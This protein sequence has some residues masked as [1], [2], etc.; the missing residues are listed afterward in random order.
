MTAPGAG[1]APLPRDRRGDLRALLAT[2]GGLLFAFSVGAAF[3]TVFVFRPERVVAAAVMEVLP[4]LGARLFANLFTVALVLLYGAFVRPDERRL[5]VRW[6]TVPAMAIVVS[7]I[8]FGVQSALGL[9]TAPT[10]PTFIGEVSS[11]AIVVVIAMVLALAQVDARR[12][13]R[14]QERAGAR[15]ELRATAAL[16]ALAS[17]ELRVRREVAEGLHGTVQ[18]QLVLIEIQIDSIVE[19]A[20]RGR[21]DPDD[22]DALRRV[23]SDLDELRERDVRELSQLLYPAGVS[24]GVAHALRLL[25][26]RLPPTIATTLVIDERLDS[27][28]DDEDLAVE[29]RVVLVRAAEE[30]ITNALRHGKAGRIRIELAPEETGDDEI[31]LTVD[32]DGRGLDADDD[33]RSGLARAA[34]RA[35]NLGGRLE[36]SASDQGGTRLTVVI[37]ARAAVT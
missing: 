19:R 6:W 7:L 10:W 23:R 5:S 17:E 3:Q 2:A 36:L 32:D 25:T 34:E 27:T 20:A 29:R 35:E 4:E 9:H 21:L 8:R 22:L 31:R 30:G 11:A 24:L 37:P 13:L 18:N 26:K 16:A 15:Q 33:R 28:A 12:G 1:D 14:M